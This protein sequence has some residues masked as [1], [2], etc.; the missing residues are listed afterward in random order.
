MFSES[1]FSSSPFGTTV[2]IV[3]AGFVERHY[4]T[5]FIQQGLDLTGS[6]SQTLGKDLSIQQRQDNTLVLSKKVKS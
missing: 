2:T 5:L 1:P 4:F 6:I 3:Q